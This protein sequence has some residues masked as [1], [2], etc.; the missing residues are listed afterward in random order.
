MISFIIIGK[1]EGWKLTKC[2]ESVYLA[3]KQ[4][5]LKDYDVIYVDSK[6]TDNS[7]ERAKKFI[8]TQIFMLT[9]EI[10]AAIARNIGV[11]ESKGEILFFIDGD[12]EIN[13]DFIW[14][15]INKSGELIYKFVSGQVINLNYDKNDVYLSEEL[16]YPDLKKGDQYFPIS[17]GVFLIKRSL[18]E[19]V[20]GMDISFRRGQDH[21]LA[22]RLAKR[23]ILLLRKADVICKHHTISYAHQDR[24][25][26]TL[27]SGDVAY[28][29][30]FI[31]MKHFFNKYIIQKTVREN[32]TTLFLVFCSCLMIFFQTLLLY[33]LY[34]IVIL[35]KVYKNKKKRVFDN[36]ELFVYYIIK[37]ILFI[38]YLFKSKR[39][40]RIT[41]IKYS[42]IN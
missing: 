7:I 18:W 2:L 4:N 10:N 41:D 31:F 9:G 25:W 35:F 6:S 1:N 24:I 13:A 28:Y 27:I 16:M 22:L 17:G 40:V 37:D 33:S 3:I 8:K 38:F 12:M 5:H 21:D 20:K 26:N 32:Y 39:K 23:G 15:S 14:K 30:S 36:F 11:H 34:F 19:E 29:S 42:R